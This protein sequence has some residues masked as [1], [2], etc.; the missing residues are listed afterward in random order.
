LPV[1][2]IMFTSI[3][4]LPNR[5]D[6]S[7]TS[8]HCWGLRNRHH[9][10]LGLAQTYPCLHLTTSSCRLFSGGC[11]VLAHG[12]R[13]RCT[14]PWEEWTRYRDPRRMAY[15]QHRG[16]PSVG[17]KPPQLQEGRS[18]QMESHVT[19]AP[20]TRRFQAGSLIRPMVKT[21]ASTGNRLALSVEISRRASP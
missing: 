6:G 7:L 5:R 12:K 20:G 4:T 19:P 2:E 10:K 9:S 18:C 14:T 13:Y 3:E 17:P 21:T 15:R 8:I 11:R 1:L 16:A